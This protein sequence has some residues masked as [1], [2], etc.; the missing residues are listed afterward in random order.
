VTSASD[1]GQWPARCFCSSGDA[2]LAMRP[3]KKSLFSCEPLPGGAQPLCR[4]VSGFAA[5]GFSY[6]FNSKHLAW[7][8]IQPVSNFALDFN[9][10]LE[11]TIKANPHLGPLK[12]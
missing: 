3:L 2:A 5:A 6:R 1:S 10:P 4:A 12:E 9:R 8:V 11:L 7:D